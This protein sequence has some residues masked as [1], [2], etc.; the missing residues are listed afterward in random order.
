MPC[1]TRMLVFSTKLTHRRP[2]ATF[3][4]IQ[5]K[6]FSW[7]HEIWDKPFIRDF[8]Q[9]WKADST[10]QVWSSKSV[11]KLVDGSR[12]YLLIAFSS[13]TKKSI[14]NEL[15]P[16]FIWQNPSRHF[17]PLWSP[18][19]RAYKCRG[20]SVG[21]LKVPVFIQLQSTEIC[22]GYNFVTSTSC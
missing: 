3:S 15:F 13:K 5:H 4:T 19:K 2:S 12:L 6:K 20:L 18:S 21:P 22:V 1:T 7:Q 8:Y 17:Y 16:V 14:L 9:F 10:L 11:N